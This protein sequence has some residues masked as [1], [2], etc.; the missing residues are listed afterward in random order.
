[1]VTATG[2]SLSGS[3]APNYALSS[4]TASTN[5]KINP[6]SVTAS[7]TASDKTY[8]GANTAMVTGCT[9]TGVLAAD[10]ANVSCG[11]AAATFASAN[12]GTWMVTATGI[13]L[14]G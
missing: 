1:M 13:S 9:L 14:S 2:I 4:A 11:A 6:K 8:D 3:A 12:A 10:A 5:A 7:V